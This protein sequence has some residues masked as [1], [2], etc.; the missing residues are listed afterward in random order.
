[1]QHN[2]TKKRFAEFL[3]ARAARQGDDKVGVLSLPYSL[4][5]LS[6][7]FY[8]R[9]RVS[10]CSIT[11]RR[12][13]LPSSF[14]SFSFPC[15]S[16]GK[17]KP[18]HNNETTTIHSFFFFFLLVGMISQTNLFYITKI[19]TRTKQLH[20]KDPSKERISSARCIFSLVFH[21][22]CLHPSLPAPHNLLH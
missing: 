16:E 20:L 21:S 17:G 12:R 13:D 2:E 7:L 18:E 6:F 5:F 1:M 14:F 15:L 3:S 9:R 10:L 22:V 4:F 11:K 19:S 8:L